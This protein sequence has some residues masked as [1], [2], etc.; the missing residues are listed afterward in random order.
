MKLF[1]LYLLL[2]SVF[3]L[4]GCDNSAVKELP[5]KAPETKS[6]TANATEKYFVIDVRS[7]EEWDE[8]H[9]DSA[10]HIPHTEVADRVS[11]VT[12]NKEAKIYLH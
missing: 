10:I 3:L 1:R 12:D 9:L 11:E 8:G 6:A 5:A 4:V 2:L 7:Q